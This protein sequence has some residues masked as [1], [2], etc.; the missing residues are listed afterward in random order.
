LYTKT[1]LNA[2]LNKEK[3]WIRK[4]GSNNSKLK[5]NCDGVL[6]MRYYMLD[7]GLDA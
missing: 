1:K 2:K 6:Q 5:P 7:Q 4:G 3:R